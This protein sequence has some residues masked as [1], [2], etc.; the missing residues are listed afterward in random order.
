MVYQRYQQ[1]CISCIVN[2]SCIF[3]IV[4][5]YYM[6]TYT[7]LHCVLNHPH[8]TM[9]NVCLFSYNME[10]LYLR[11]S[12]DKCACHDDTSCVVSFITYSKG[13]FNW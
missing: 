4:N 5:V 3:Q 7:A 13:Y 10:L 12:L 6:K 2:D 9:L 8:I 11:C 1:C